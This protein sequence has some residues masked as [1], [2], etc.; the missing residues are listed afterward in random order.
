MENACTIFNKQRLFKVLNV[1]KQTCIEPN[2]SNVE[3]SITVTPCKYFEDM[4]KLRAKLNRHEVIRNLPEE[5][6]NL[7]T[8]DT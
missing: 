5:C 3:N 4:A 1:K 6:G 7:E 2:Y 8:F